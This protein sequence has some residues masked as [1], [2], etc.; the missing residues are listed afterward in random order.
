MR[1]TFDKQPEKARELVGT[2]FNGK[3]IFRPKETS[4]GPRFE[5]E[6]IAAPGRLLAV[7]G[8]AQVGVLKGASPGG[9]ELSI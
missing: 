7:E 5:L 2:L 9:F 8:L 1:Q 6:G 3:I 4:E